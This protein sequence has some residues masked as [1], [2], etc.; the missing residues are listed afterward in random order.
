MYRILKW[1][2]REDDSVKLNGGVLGKVR[3]QECGWQREG[4][5]P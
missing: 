5:S 2:K 3:T 1:E 4:I